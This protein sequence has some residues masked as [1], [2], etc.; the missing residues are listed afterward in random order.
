[1][2]RLRLIELLADASFHRGRRVEL[3]EVAQATGIH[4]TT[5][6]RMINVRGY[7]ATLSNVDA[8]CK[9]LGC[10]VGDVATYIPDEDVPAAVASER[11][12]P[13]KTDAHT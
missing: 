2:T 6:S 13:A 1:M 5:L 12:S 10:S 3:M 11:P 7:N 4:R 8:L 9:F